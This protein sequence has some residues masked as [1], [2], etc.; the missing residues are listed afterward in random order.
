M[1]G[2]AMGGTDGAGRAPPGTRPRTPCSR[3]FVTRPFPT[4]GP[5]RGSRDSPERSA[6]RAACLPMPAGALA[7]AARRVGCEGEMPN[8]EAK[9]RAACLPVPA[10]ALAG[11][12]RRAGREGEMPGAVRQTEVGGLTER[13]GGV[14]GSAVGC[15][16]GR[17]GRVVPPV[18][19]AGPGE[20]WIKCGVTFSRPS[21]PFGRTRTRSVL[22]LPT[23]DGGSGWGRAAAG[24]AYRRAREWC[25]A[26]E[27]T[28]D[29][30]SGSDDVPCLP[31][32]LWMARVGERPSP[33]R[34]LVLRT[35]LEGSRQSEG[36]PLPPC[37]ATLLGTRRGVGLEVPALLRSP[38]ASG[39]P[40]GSRGTVGSRSLGY[41]RPCG[42]GGRRPPACPDKRAFCASCGRRPFPLWPLG[43]A[44]P[45][46][47]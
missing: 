42:H 45:A 26:S 43:H 29:P 6:C 18:D 47:R 14:R 46:R 24:L 2:G 19:P 37:G 1:D 15:P 8:A 33:R 35:Y 21:G 40:V 12:A 38:C 3:G 22:A 10:G 30:C 34:F 39:R 4:S 9:C 31:L 20:R 11:A 16:A 36:E 41:G 27:G 28:S 5:T 32:Q 17:A 25:L 13:P 44:V 7:G 23:G